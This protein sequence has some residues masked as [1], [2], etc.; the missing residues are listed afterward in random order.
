MVKEEFLMP[1]N[2]EHLATLD[3]LKDVA[4]RVISKTFTLA[5][6]AEAAEMLDEVFG[7]E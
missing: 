2:E 3:S 1:Y 6:D 4:E 5:S 7:S